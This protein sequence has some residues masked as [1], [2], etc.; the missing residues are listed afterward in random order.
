MVS[1]G[2][3]SYSSRELAEKIERLGAS[4]SVSSS[5]DFTILAASALSIYDDDILDLMQEMI[6]RP[7]FP[8][9]ELDLYRRNTIEHL[10]F[11]RSQPGFLAGEQTARLIYGNHPYS[12]VSPS[13]ADIENLS[14]DVL[15]EFHSRV[16]VP[17]NAVLIVVGDIDHDEVVKEIAARFGDRQRGAIAKPAYPA[18]PTRSKRTL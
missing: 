11:Q 18:S 7:S 3:E 12:R 5:D 2:T 16:Y 9:D 1:E 17:N 8:E 6:L 10:K 15:V 4:I 13:P 14:R